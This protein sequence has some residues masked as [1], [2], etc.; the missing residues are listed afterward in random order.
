MGKEVL[1]PF[2]MREEGMRDEGQEMREACR[3]SL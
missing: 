3:I 1:V 2:G